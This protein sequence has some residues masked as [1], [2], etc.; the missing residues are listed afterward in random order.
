MSLCQT[1]F[2]KLYRHYVNNFDK[3]IQIIQKA[4]TKQKAFGKFVSATLAL[5]DFKGLSLSSYLIMPVQRI[6]RYVL[7]VTELIKNTILSHPD[8]TKLQ[9]AVEGLK[10]LADFINASKAESE[11]ST[12]ITAMRS[13]IV[14]I[15]P[16]DFENLLRGRRWI[17]EGELLLKVN[18]T[19]RKTD[20]TEAMVFLLSDSLIITKPKGKDQYKFTEAI[21]L[22][23]VVTATGSSRY[24]SRHPHCWS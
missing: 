21:R 17:K 15:A 16:A 4:Q 22:N 11:N 10:A 5:P 2:I 8:Y 1:K 9:S 13:K 7:L 12:K 19:D 20:K 24:F 14:D 18:A 6:P 3:N 23:A